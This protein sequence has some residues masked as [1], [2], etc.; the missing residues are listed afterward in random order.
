MSLPGVRAQLM[1]L[2]SA[3]RYRADISTPRVLCIGRKLSGTA[4]LYDPAKYTDES[5]VIAAFGTNSELHKAWYELVSAGATEIYLEGIDD[6][7]DR[8]E[9][10]EKAYATAETALPDV[11]VP[12]GQG[13]PI[14][15]TQPTDGA[16]ADISVSGSIEL[17]DDESHTFAGNTFVVDYPYNVS[18]VVVYS[19][20][21]TPIAYTISTDYTFDSETGV[22]TRVTTGTIPDTA[23][24]EVLVTYSYSSDYANQ[25]A[26]W[27]ER[28]TD[29]GI[30]CIGVI[31]CQ[32]LAKDVGDEDDYINEARKQS[33]IAILL[34]D[35]P[36][37]ET[38]LAERGKFI[39]IVLGETKFV[40]QDADWGFNNGA[41]P[42][43]A[44]IATLAVQSA[45]T[46]KPIYNV[47]TM[48]YTFSRSQLETLVDLGIV[49]VNIDFYDRPI[50]VDAT[51]YAKNGSDY[52]RLTTVRI[53]LEAVKQVALVASKFIGEGATLERRN[54]LE[55]AIRGVLQNMKV[56]GALNDADFHITFY[57]LTN[58][59]TVDLLLTPAWE[60]RTITETVTIKTD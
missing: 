60:I 34:E 28:F 22:V 32:P 50:A 48:R 16:Y 44:L 15:G 58:S 27:C 5:A 46:N 37:R 18:A 12:Y 9:E 35:L 20:D 21:A 30:P 6:S 39:S 59:A 7:E 13:T 26:T 24:L 25:L 31:G 55:T 45:P 11:M 56:A 29:L 52:W 8:F 47:N 36:D 54:A 40:G 42:Y 1:D 57:Q 19:N 41:C 51:T 2:Y 4:N 33:E 3:L 53:A 49:P 17:V 38:A 43:A 10:L 14:D 23:G